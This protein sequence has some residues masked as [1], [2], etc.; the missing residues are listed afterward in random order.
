MKGGRPI[1]KR[2]SSSG[3]TL[4]ECVV[5]IAIIPIAV[6]MAIVAFTNALP[7]IRA[8]SALQT[9]QSQLL[10]ARETSVDQRRNVQVTFKGTG[11]VVTTLV[12]LNLSTTQ[13]VDNILPY[14]MVYTLFPGVPDTPD[15][16]GNTLAVS[17]IGNGVQDCAS[18]PCTITFY[19]DGSVQDGSG[20][21][22]NG[23]VFIGYAGNPLTARSVTILGATGCIH[24]YRYNGNA[25]F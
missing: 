9:L 2:H 23:T 8:D 18:L 13:L 10:Q 7:T 14:T 15:G 19:S 20:N 3:F 5:T 22:V 1:V 25:W 16:Y 4:I 17:F 12:N 24:G 11:E 21:Y 6:G